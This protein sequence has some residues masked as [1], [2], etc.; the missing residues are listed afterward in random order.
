MAAKRAQQTSGPTTALIYTR[1]STD[2]QRTDGASLD[3]QLTECRRYVGRQQ[4]WRIGTEFTDVISGLKDNRPQYQALLAEVRR[5]RADGYAVVVTVAALDR[6]GRRLL[7]R[8]RAREELKSLGVA[9]HSV[10]KGGEV[11]DLVA[12]VLGA[13]AQE[14]VRRLGERV[15]ASRRHV[16]ALGWAPVGEAAWGYRW[17]DAMTKERAAGAPKRVLEPDPEAAPFVREAFERVAVGE[18]MRS[19][20][21]WARDLPSAARSNKPMVFHT[22][23]RALRSPTY[24]GRSRT[25]DG[26]ARAKPPGHWSA[27]VDDVTWREVQRRQP[28]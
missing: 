4:A 10:R 15:L 23:L 8:V 7:E 6:L 22:V 5:L 18:S 24:V 3:V 1:M 16:A 19:V 27:I 2:E 26:D 13:V 12:N 14:E 11:S 25:R 9:T 20:A 17:R 21:R 28:P